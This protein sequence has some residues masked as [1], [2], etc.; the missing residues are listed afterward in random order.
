[1]SDKSTEQYEEMAKHFY[2]G[3]G[4]TPASQIT[5]V[6]D[7]GPKVY[8]E[9]L[10]DLRLDIARTLA[11]DTEVLDVCCGNGQHL[12]SLD[13]IF[14]FGIGLDFS[15]PYIQHATSHINTQKTGFTCGNA[16]ILPFKSNSFGLIY[17][18]SA[19]YGIPESSEVVNEISR[20]LKTGGKCILD[21]GNLYSLNAL[22]RW[23]LG[24]KLPPTFFF[25]V[26]QLK[27]MIF[28]SHLRI[29]EHRA[30]QIL[31]LWETNDPWWLS[32]ILWRGWTQLLEKQFHDRML[33]EWIS[34]LPILKYLAFR[35]IF[36]CEKI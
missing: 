15:L 14:K 2:I 10:I 28:D 7:R 18:F 26:N 36:V 16:R 22:V 32:P 33:D 8:G 1:M 4:S 31:P 34:N 23:G 11:K 30:F 17:A 20:V 9:K 25:P 13:G 29:L 27:K 35:H 21:M 6:P 19:L 24:D 3:D 12:Q 5:K